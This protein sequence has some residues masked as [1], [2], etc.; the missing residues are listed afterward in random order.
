MERFRVELDPFYPGQWAI[1]RDVRWPIYA[2]AASGRRKALRRFVRAAVVR[3]SFG[4]VADLNDAPWDLPQLIFALWTSHFRMTQEEERELMIRI[5]AEQANM[6]IEH[7]EE[8]NLFNLLGVPIA[9][10]SKTAPAG[11]CLHVAEL[12]AIKREIEIEN[13][14]HQ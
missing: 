14:K 3:L 2:A 6:R 1:L 8:Y 13:G 7:L 10:D 4:V 9:R 12:L 11:K 5:S